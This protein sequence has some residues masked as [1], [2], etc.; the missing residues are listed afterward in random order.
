[1]TPVLNLT[2]EQEE[3]LMRY[4]NLRGKETKDILLEYVERLPAPVASNPDATPAARVSGLYAGKIRTSE[5]FDDP[6]PDSF[7]G[8]EE[9]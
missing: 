4:A 3:R 2:P 7:W 9:E 8:G 6:L 1:M 5:D